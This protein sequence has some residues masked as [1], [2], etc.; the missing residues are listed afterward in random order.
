MLIATSSHRCTACSRTPCTASTAFSV[1]GRHVLSFFLSFFF[2][3]GTSSFPCRAPQECPESVQ[4]TAGVPGQAVDLR[5]YIKNQKGFAREAVHICTHMGTHLCLHCMI[6]SVF[7][8]PP[9]IPPSPI[10]PLT[11]QRPSFL[12]THS[13]MA[14]QSGLALVGISWQISYAVK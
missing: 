6:R 13:V 9:I 8:I 7:T 10:S 2:F 4:S 1:L 14:T 11:A 5:V 3:I 12:P